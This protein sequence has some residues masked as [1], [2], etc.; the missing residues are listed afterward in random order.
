[1]TTDKTLL[2]GLDM[3]PAIAS[4][5]EAAQQLRQQP[6]YKVRNL[7][8]VKESLDQFLATT[9]LDNPLALGLK[10]MGGGASKEQFV[11]DLQ[12]EGK[13]TER[14]VL[15][16]D[17]LESAV[18]TSREREHAILEL[19]QGVVP[20][21]KPLWCDNDGSKLGRPALITD[22]VSGVTKPTASTSNVSGFGTVFDKDTRK[23]LSGPFMKHFAAMHSVEWKN[24]GYDCFQAP[25]NDPQ[26]AARW[27]LNWWTTVWTGDV[28]EG[29]PLMGLAERWMRDN[30]PAASPEDLVFVHSD[31]RTGNYLYSEANDE[32]TAIL[33]W[34]LVHIGD[35]HEDLAWAAIRS[36]S[37]VEEGTLLA[38][39]LMPVQELCDKYSELT[40][41]SVNM[42]S[43]YFYQVLGLYKCVAICLATSVNAAKHAHNHQD[44][45][46][47]WL[48]AAGYAFLTDLCALLERGSAE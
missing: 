26:Q 41:R 35:F 12:Q 48:A 25:T 27:A 15:R 16:M 36:W 44:A 34:E 1:M 20:V 47:S 9:D 13:E 19:M 42:K 21:P 10:R 23:A 8:Q 46:L 32:I 17:P 39:G 18:V 5:L 11:F 38:S 33:D 4:M 2:Q 22:F 29:Y 24:S 30:L 43:L 6:P 45:L 3:E 31:Y 40:G 37:T 28:S 7:E 14:C